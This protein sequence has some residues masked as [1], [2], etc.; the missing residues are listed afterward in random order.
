MMKNSPK[1]E[2]KPAP[3]HDIILEGREKLSVTGVKRVL[4][5]N[6]ESAAIE[7]SMGVLNLSGAQLSVTAL[8]LDAGQAKLSGR[9]DTLAYTEARTAG[10]FM[11]RL[12]R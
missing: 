9:F 6:A 12:L 1:P 3:P 7:T 2:E 4:Y 8:D 5:C 11:R 10:G